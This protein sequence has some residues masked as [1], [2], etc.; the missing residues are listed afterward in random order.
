MKQYKP[1]L[2]NISPHIKIGKD[3][4]V[5]SHVVIY[6]NV[7]IGNRVKIQAFV[8]I[9][10]GV[11]IGD[12]VFLGPRVT[13]TNDKHPPSNGKDWSETIVKDGVSIGA[14]AVI[15]PGITIGRNAIIGAGAVVTKN[16]QANTTVVGNPARLLIKKDNK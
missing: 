9:P 4:I 6:D 10:N 14:G 12:D 13:F 15:L 16:V 2:S 1:E 7:E 5:H 11:T 8:F 3:C